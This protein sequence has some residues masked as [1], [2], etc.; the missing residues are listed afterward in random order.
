[1]GRKQNCGRGLRVSRLLAVSAMAVMGVAGLGQT[2]NASNV[3]SDNAGNTPYFATS[4]PQNPNGWTTGMNG[5]TG[6]GA[7]ELSASSTGGYFINSATNDNITPFFDIYDTSR[8]PNGN[9]TSATRPFTGGALVVGQSVSFDFVLNGAGAGSFVGFSLND[10]SQNPL[11]QF[12]QAGF[13][14]VAGYV[15]DASGTTKGVG[16]AYNYQ[17]LDTVSF[18][19]TSPTTYNFDVNG[20]LAHAGTISDSTGGIQSLTFFDNG[21][22]PGSDVQ[23]TNLAISAVPA[24]STL[25]IFVGGLGLVALAARRR[26]HAKA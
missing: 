15:T 13:S 22:G 10:S 23:F 1:M 7:W 3:A 16:V 24:P 25:A 19:L 26:K 18:T 21:A 5:G 12:E 14:S 11:F 9:T 20:S 6:F 2:A 8:A 17:T 4:G